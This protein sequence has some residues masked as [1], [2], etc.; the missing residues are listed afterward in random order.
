MLRLPFFVIASEAKQS[1]CVAVSTWIPA[2]AGMTGKGRNDEVT[3]ASSF[4]RKQGSIYSTPIIIHVTPAFFRHCEQSEA[5]RMCCSQHLDSCLRRNGGEREEWRHKAS[6]DDS[7]MFYSIARLGAWRWGKARNDEVTTA[8]SFLRKQGS[9]YST[10][11]TIHVT[12]AFFRHC[13]QSEAIRMCCSQ[14]LDS[15]LRRNDGE[16]EE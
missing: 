7:V 14:H 10:P 3:T 9:I 4:L 16:R 5:I 8:P 2:C 1:R 6:S 13:E 11:I 12:P 15:C